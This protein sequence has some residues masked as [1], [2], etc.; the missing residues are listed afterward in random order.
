MFNDGITVIV[1]HEAR[2]A[3]RDTPDEQL[4]FMEF[5]ENNLHPM[6]QV[7]LGKKIVEDYVKDGKPVNI[8]T[9]SPDFLQSIHLHSKIHN[10]PLH[11][12]VAEKDKTTECTDSLDPAFESFCDS[13]DY[14]MQL[15]SDIEHPDKEPE[16]DDDE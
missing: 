4:T 6:E 1:G 7:R 14:L 8:R 3:F 13:F 2:T 5:P 16:S 15:R 12:L 10:V 11:V 9:F